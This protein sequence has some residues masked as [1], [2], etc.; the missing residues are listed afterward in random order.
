MSAR[1]LRGDLLP[2]I[3]APPPGPGSRALSRS[4]AA[5]E[6]PGINTLG[7]AD[8]PAVVWAEALGA[9]VLDVDGNRYV[10]LTAGFGVAAVGH[11]PPPVVAAV[12]EQASRLLHG[13]GD[14]AAHPA[15]V[16]L[17]ERLAAISP[18][19]SPRVHFAV[20]GADAVEVALKSALAATGRAG[21][22]AFD[23][24]YHGTTLG[25][26]AATSR[27]AFRAPFSAHLHP[28]VV[29]LP[30]ASPIAA[31]ERCLAQHAIGAVIVEPVVGREGV[32]VPPRGWL[33]ELAA[34][35]R[36]SGALLVAD[37]VFTGF[38]RTGELFAVDHDGVRP[39][40]LCLGKALGGGL[41]LAAVVGRGEVMEVWRSRGDALHTATFLAHPL[42]CAAALATLDL[43]RELD[44]VARARAL[45]ESLA[46]SLDDLFAGGAPGLSAVRGR[47]ALWAIELADAARA[48]S[49]VRCCRE[50][51]VLLLAGGHS[52]RVVQIAPPLIITDEQLAVALAVIGESVANGA[53][54][55]AR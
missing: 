52:G 16:E 4:L 50:R 29:R 36:A 21:V 30:F 44:L 18:V 25:A 27:D 40:L 42:A 49:V 43:I 22:L 24:A 35:A 23:P 3:V 51:G 46:P 32:L 53:P 10:D 5:H 31:I 2:A 12:A 28:H 55:H 17:A 54:A 34:A 41:P 39:D 9:N 38:G 14:V 33:A 45:G 15:R 47:G 11:R 13:L 48:Q 37:E 8:E 20:S 6:A 1:L 19:D 26:L 7:A